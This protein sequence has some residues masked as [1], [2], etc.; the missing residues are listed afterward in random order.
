M[1]PPGLNHA[2][3]GCSVAYVRKLLENKADVNGVDDYGFFPLLLAVIA[4]RDDVVAVLL[5]E[6]VGVD[7][8][9]QQRPSPYPYPAS[10]VMYA[11]HLRNV[12]IV[13]MLLAAKADVNETDTGRPV[14]G[15][16]ALHYAVSSPHVALQLDWC[17]SVSPYRRLRTRL[18]QRPRSP[19]IDV[20]LRAGAS[21]NY[22]EDYLGGNPLFWASSGFGWFDDDLQVH[23]LLQSSGA[24]Y[25][26]RPDVPP[27][28]KDVS[29][30]VNI[31]IGVTD[32]VDEMQTY[33]Q[34]YPSQLLIAA[35]ADHMCKDLVSMVTAYA[36][37][38]MWEII[39][40]LGIGPHY[41]SPCY[42]TF[43]T[44]EGN[45]QELHDDMFNIDEF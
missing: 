28:Y 33:I 36:T 11:C 20:L 37:P 13:A 27:G 18:G 22:C 25:Y 38:T 5:A 35:L 3:Q 19:T 44:W 4:E 16:S 15:V 39:Q 30:A 21:V 6:N 24:I 7:V 34:D 9:K 42:G 10:A 14:A 12:K 32:A 26:G 1:D 41:V 8:K 40:L 17:D 2:V 29:G 45:L 43:T 31:T 23:A